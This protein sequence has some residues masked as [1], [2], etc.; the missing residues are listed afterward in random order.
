MAHY[1]SERTGEDDDVVPDLFLSNLTSQQETSYMHRVLPE[2]TCRYYA[3][4]LG[5]EL[6]E[7]NG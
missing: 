3:E 2:I 6:R 7:W 1:F 5:M 4:G